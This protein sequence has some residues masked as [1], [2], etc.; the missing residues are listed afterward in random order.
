MTAGDVI[1]EV[2][3]SYI[4]PCHHLKAIHT[5]KWDIA[6]SEHVVLSYYSWHCDGA[7]VSVIEVSGCEG[8]V[9]YHLL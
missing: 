9:L 1:A 3:L 4:I 6:S 5:T 2:A 7:D 8:E